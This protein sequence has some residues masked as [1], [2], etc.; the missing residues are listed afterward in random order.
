VAGEYPSV[1]E[2]EQALERLEELGLVRERQRAG[3]REYAPTVDGEVE[4]AAWML[5]GMDTVA[6]SI[7]TVLRRARDARAELSRQEVV[8]LV[9]VL[10]AY[11]RDVY[12]RHLSVR[13]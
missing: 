12:E 2:V 4:L 6:A 13:G 5:Q 1:G 9:Q 7:L 11:A 3:R 8:R 10:E